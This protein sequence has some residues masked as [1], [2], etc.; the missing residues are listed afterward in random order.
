[1]KSTL[2]KIVK[3]LLGPIPIIPAKQPRSK[4]CHIQIPDKIECYYDSK[5]PFQKNR[6]V[7][8][9][10]GYI[11]KEAAKYLAHSRFLSPQDL[12]KRHQY[13]IIYL[14]LYDILE[15]WR[16]QNVFI[17]KYKHHYPAEISYLS[18]Y[19]D[20]NVEQF[21][22]SNEILDDVINLLSIYCKLGFFPKTLMIRPEIRNFLYTT[23]PTT[24]QTVA[25]WIQ[26]QYD[27]IVKMD[28]NETDAVDQTA[29]KL[30]K[31][32]IEIKSKSTNET[33]SQY[34]KSDPVDHSQSLDS[35]TNLSEDLEYICNDFYKYLINHKDALHKALTQIHQDNKYYP[36]RINNY[37]HNSVEA[38]DHRYLRFDPW[39]SL[40]DLIDDYKTDSG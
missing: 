33:H 21:R 14:Y 24:K 13:P 4:S 5:D 25:E 30:Y 19:N 40:H 15:D 10:K 16:C 39:A 35:K 32:V 31:S 34:S 8:H 20:Q 1:M 36:N 17:N 3:K 27:T 29:E 37:T 22:L 38:E 2:E 9:Y 23:V 28:I 18:L 12:K 6:N 26:F 7:L 11:V